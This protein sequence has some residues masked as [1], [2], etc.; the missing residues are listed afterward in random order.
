MAKL[1]I[2]ESPAK[3][4]TINRYLGKDYVVK[5][6]M[7]HVRDL[8]KSSMG[9]DIEKDFKPT[10][11]VMPGRNK[12]LS[13]LR[14]AAAKADEVFLA[15]DLDREGE[16]IAW[17]LAQALKLKKAQTRRV[18]FNEITRNAIRRA[19]EEPLEIDENKVN[20]QQARRI[21]DRIVGYQLSPLLW[22]KLRRGLSAG[23]VQ[24]VAVRLIVD[25]EREIEAFKPEEY[26]EID[27]DFAPTK[28]HPHEPRKFTAKLARV[29]GE[30]ASIPNE[31]E[32]KA[33]V[34]GIT[35]A[36]IKVAQVE[37]KER[38]LRPYPPFTTSTLQQQ[39][40]I[41][42]RF[43][44]KK[45]MMLAQQLY[46]GV[47]LGD[48]GAVGLITYMRTDSQRVS[49]QAL[50]ECRDHIGQHFAADYL[51]EKAQV[52]RSGK[53]AQGA[54][55]AIR[56]TAAAYTP[57]R[58]KQFLTRDQFR[59]YDLIW[60]RFV[61]SQM[62]PGRLA[63][64]DVQIEAG[65]AMFAAQGRRLVFDG[66]LK[67]SGYDAKSDTALPTLAV[68]DPLKMLRVEPSQHFTKPPPRYTEATLVKT[69]EKLGI[70]RPSTYAPI[71]S[72]IRQ[73]H[74]V[75]LAKR[76][77]S[78]T[79]LG[80]MVTD[81]LVEHF[82]DIMD[83]G[84]TSNMEERLDRVEE[85]EAD[86]LQALRAFYKPFAA[87]MKKAEKNM[88]RP[89]PEQ[90]E[91]KC[92]ECGKPMVKRWSKRGS[93][94][95]C[96]GYPECKFTMSL[97]SEGN[98][99]ERPAPEETDEKCEKCGAPMVIRT[100]RHGR[101]LA[102]SAFPKCKNTRSLEKTPDV[103]EDMKKCEECGGEMIV[104]RGRR[105]PFLGCSNYPKCRNTKP[106]PKEEKSGS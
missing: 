42:L 89:E 84:F 55:E 35:K 8:P 74:Y 43:S 73:R 22:K 92:K 67:V 14:K 61:A 95:G 58:V 51:P 81:K 53:N 13:E 48:E 2:V 70:G 11:R 104:R 26:W 57:E 31:A 47:E 91:H 75:E 100:G 106:L 79:E 6:S 3:A 25:R 64:T 68:G 5:A 15:T 59:L 50:A 52:Y 18:I 83:V 102:C 20:A 62:T 29:D 10:Y 19:F 32:A 69:L 60:T 36:D 34:E 27:A 88:K 86:W 44:A 71:L 97:D 21:L 16:A 98:P 66:H 9:V 30:K 77:F 38:L 80:K 93:F 65:R 72:T 96:S 37:E 82:A 24:S 63:V 45:T 28:R 7:G 105:G 103:P 23:R 41:R 78:A 40:S 12:T 101:F 17:H 85:G 1:V 54:H 56:P 4:R 39:A 90:T 33:L 49:N 76:Q 99:S 87:D 94:L 46:E